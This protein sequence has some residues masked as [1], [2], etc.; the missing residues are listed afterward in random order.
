MDNFDKF[1]AESK[2]NRRTIG[3]R[4]RDTYSFSDLG[5]NGTTT[6]DNQ[7]RNRRPQV[8]GLS[9]MGAISHEQAEADYT[10]KLE[11]WRLDEVH[12]VIAAAHTMTLTLSGHALTPDTIAVVSSPPI[13]EVARTTTCPAWPVS[14]TI[15]GHDLDT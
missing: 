14:T 1:I 12:P 13:T 5:K 4:M 8:C 11:R 3:S 9:D 2:A 10:T 6:N 7:R 15:L